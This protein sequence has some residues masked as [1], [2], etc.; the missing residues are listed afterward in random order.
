MVLEMTSLL[1]LKIVD[2]SAQGGRFG[3]ASASACVLPPSLPPPPSPFPPSLPFACHCQ[4]PSSQP[5]LSPA[6]CT[7]PEGLHPQ[8]AIHNPPQPDPPHPQSPLVF[9]FI[10]C[11]QGNSVLSNMGIC[12]SGDT[13][14]INPNAVDLTHFELGRVLG[15]G[16]FGKV[17]AVEKRSEPDKGEWFAMKQLKKAEIVRRGNAAE[18]FQELKLLATLNSLWICNSYCKCVGSGKEWCGLE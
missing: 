17:Y 14:A 2:V 10:S 15:R 7:R 9:F 18:V 5:C 12:A 13:R 1:S 16:G 11:A 8:P 4:T 3:R 6:D